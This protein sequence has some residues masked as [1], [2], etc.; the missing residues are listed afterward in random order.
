[1]TPRVNVHLVKVSLSR[2][3]LQNRG[4]GSPARDLNKGWLLTHQRS[5]KTPADDGSGVFL[6]GLL[7]V[8]Q[9]PAADQRGRR[10]MGPQLVRRATHVRFRKIIEGTKG[11][12]CSPFPLLNPDLANS[13][14]AIK[15]NIEPDRF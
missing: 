8:C 10:G 9:D 7:A 4:E 6:G 11:C 5:G 3:L 12:K 14:L 1:M 15:K 13:L 2:A